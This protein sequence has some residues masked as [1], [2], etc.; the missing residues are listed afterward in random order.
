M[1][2][3]IIII[4]IFFYAKAFNS[5]RPVEVEG[6]VERALWLVY[7]SASPVLPTPTIWFSL[8]RK[9]QKPEENGNVLMASDSDSVALM[10][11]IRVLI[12]TRS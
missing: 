10:K 5:I 7:P 1:I 2:I 8:D 9:R 12:F 6:E 11:P 4:L 3:I